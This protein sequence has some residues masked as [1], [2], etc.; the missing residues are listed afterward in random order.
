MPETD[1]YQCA[2]CE[3]FFTARTADRKRGWARFCSK[4]CKAKQQC[5]NKRRSE[6]S[7]NRAQTHF[8]WKKCNCGSK[9][10]KLEYPQEIG[11]FYQG[12]GFSPDE[13][14]MIENAFKAKVMLANAF[15]ALKAADDLIQN[16][17]DH[18]GAEGFS[19]ST[20]E[21]ANRYERATRELK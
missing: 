18:E 7:N 6:V 21:L 5:A 12:T 15:L 20:R 11:S 9:V 4:S 1:V 3:K 8:T 19:I 14:E 13:K 17:Y 16:L 2:Y 10:C